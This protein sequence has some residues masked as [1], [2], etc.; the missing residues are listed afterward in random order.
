M[1][2]PLSPDLLQQLQATLQARRALLDGQ[3]QDHLEG[4]SRAE[5][6]RTVLL[7]DGDDAPQPRCRARGRTGPGPPT[8]R[9]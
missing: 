8:R 9:Q 6:A 4:Q 7:Q 2:Q 5:H 3:R 1:T